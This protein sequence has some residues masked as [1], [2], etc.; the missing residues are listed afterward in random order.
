MLLAEYCF[1]SFQRETLMNQLVTN[2]EDI[3]LSYDELDLYEETGD[4][5]YD[6]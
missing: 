2:K 6:L 1:F 5:N 4:A 3:E